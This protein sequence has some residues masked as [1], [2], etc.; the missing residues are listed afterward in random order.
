MTNDTDN[1]TDNPPPAVKK[2]NKSI[3]TST[4][5]TISKVG[6]AIK[7]AAEYGLVDGVGGT[8][9]NFGIGVRDGAKQ[10]YNFITNEMRNE[11]IELETLVNNQLK[12]LDQN[13][14]N[15]KDQ[16][17]DLS[18]DQSYQKLGFK[19]KLH[20]FNKYIEENNIQS[21]LRKL[22]N[23]VQNQIEIANSLNYQTISDSHLQN[24]KYTSL[25]GKAKI[26]YLVKLSKDQTISDSHLQNEKYTSLD[27]KAKIDYLVKLSKDLMSKDSEIQENL[28]QRWKELLPEA[29]NLSISL[30]K[31][32]NNK[33]NATAQSDLVAR[34]ERLT[35][36]YDKSPEG[37]KIEKL[38]GQLDKTELPNLANTLGISNEIPYQNAKT[39]EEKINLIEKAL[40]EKQKSLNNQT[41]TDHPKVILKNLAQ[42]I[43]KGK[44]L[45]FEHIKTTADA[46][47]QHQDN[48]EDVEL[49][50]QRLEEAK[51]TLRSLEK[52]EA[53][54]KKKP[55]IATRIVK[56]SAAIIAG[57]LIGA[58][59]GIYN[60]T[61]TAATALVKAPSGIKSIY[62]RNKQG[63]TRH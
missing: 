35:K 41:A 14:P 21:Q 4:K 44:E 19:K 46:A 32:I 39:Y 38:K 27:D 24:E 8:I 48:Q 54:L 16:F 17:I 33:K 43:N 18:Q 5:N 45:S 25:D 36:M 63:R 56:K 52:Q 62:N 9:K 57:S 42:D 37:I 28:D 34:I 61:Q 31:G 53:K 51:K 13:F 7:S 55:N 60:A 20:L 15:N 12:V 49:A 59:K 47:L 10:G 50:L 30:M 40:L 11:L 29:Y 22:E 26:D 23:I 58:T 2:E 3:L 1:K 6:T